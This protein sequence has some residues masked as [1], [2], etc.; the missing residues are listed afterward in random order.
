MEGF[1]K[2]NNKGYCGQLVF[3]RKI[4]NIEMSDDKFNTESYVYEKKLLSGFILE[5]SEYFDGYYLIKFFTGEKEFHWGTD[6]FE[7]NLEK[8]LTY[9]KNE[10]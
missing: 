7:R 6:L 2:I 5:K 8:N 9:L 10:L 3:L 1:R 4:R